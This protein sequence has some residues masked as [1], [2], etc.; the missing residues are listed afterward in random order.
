[1]IPNGKEMFTPPHTTGEQS[2]PPCG[3][4][5]VVGA[6]AASMVT[7][8]DHAH[9]IHTEKAREIHDT[10][11]VTAMGEGSIVTTQVVKVIQNR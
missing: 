1:M 8:T 9:A 2:S 4:A 10:G 5:A 6:A 11:R 7:G 3:S